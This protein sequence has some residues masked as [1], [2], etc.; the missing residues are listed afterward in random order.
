MYRKVYL[1]ILRFALMLLICGLLFGIA[2]AFAFTGETRSS[3]FP[4]ERLR[5]LHVSC[6]VFWI[7]SAAIGGLIFYIRDFQEKKS[8]NA[9][10]PQAFAALWIVTVITIL[11]SFFYG[12][13]GGR[14]Y[15]EYPPRLSLGIL[16]AWLF[17]IVFFFKTGA[18]RIRQKPVY[19]WMWMTGIFFFLITFLE[20]NLW[21]IPWFRDNVIRD[22]T[23]QWKANGAMVGS[24]NMLVYGTSFYLMSRISGEDTVARKPVTFFFYFL[25]LTNLLF[26]WGHHTYVV[27]AAPWIRYVSYGISMTEWIIFLNIIR[28]WRHTLSDSKKYFHQI[29]YRFLLASEFWVFANLFLAL[30]MSIPAVHVYTHGTHITVAHAMGTTIGINSMILLASLF[31]ILGPENIAGSPKSHRWLM[32]GY[33][34]TN[35]FLGIF[36]LSLITAGIIKG[37]Y[38]TALGES[39]FQFVM[40]RIYPVIMVF[41]F[42]GIGLAAGLMIN[43]IILLRRSYSKP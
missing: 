23:I 5:P 22:I 8:K 19:L 39:N 6:M 27:P 12:K 33:W 41:A 31:Y 28:T 7:L 20:S 15:W 35:I 10:W 42:S 26:N 13:F 37:Y 4:F 1:H 38:I 32:I 14:E 3:W 11:G 21:Q 30:L 40:S 2:G 17:F 9:F 16:A 25:G 43:A 24:W 18:W 29:P 36:W 34:L